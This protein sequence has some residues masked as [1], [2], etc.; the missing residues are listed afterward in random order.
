[1]QGL[2]AG[3]LWRTTACVCVSEAN[4]CS[5][6]CELA[7]VFVVHQ[8]V[9]MMSS[10]W[11]V[12]LLPPASCPL[13]GF[14]PRSFTTPATPDGRRRGTLVPLLSLLPLVG[15]AIYLLLRPKTDLSS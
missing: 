4:A 13:V 3:D 11:S 8:V 10:G 7:C 9:G 12:Q 2:H 6:A 14:V 5:S 1:V 15:P